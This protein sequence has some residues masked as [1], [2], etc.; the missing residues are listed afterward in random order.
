[1]SAT[2]TPTSPTSIGWRRPESFSA[3]ATGTTR[4]AAKSCATRWPRSSN[5]PTSETPVLLAWPIPLADVDSP[6]LLTDDSPGPTGSTLASFIL[7][8]TKKLVTVVVTGPVTAPGGDGALP[9]AST[10][11]TASGITDAGS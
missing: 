5:D 9:G 6:V 2:P 7:D 10:I 11:T 1:M 4:P 8:S 3:M